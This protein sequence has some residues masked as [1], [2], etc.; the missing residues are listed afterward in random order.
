ML[1]SRFWYVILASL[2]TVGLMA[3]LVAS[4]VVNEQQRSAVENELVR[5]RITLEQALQHEAR[6]RLDALA[7]FAANR[8]VRSALRQASARR[9]GAAVPESVATG[10]A[11][12]IAE[13]NRQ[14][15]ELRGDLVF[16][17]DKEGWIVAALAPGRI[18][19]GA[20]IGE[21]PLVARALEGYMRDDVWVYNDDIYRMAARPV[22]DGGQYVGA[23]I[24]GKR[25]DDELARRLS[26]SRLN[27]ATIGFFLGTEM[28][29]GYMPDEGA[30]PRRDEVGRLLESV[31][32]D[33]ALAEGDRTEPQSLPTGGLAIYSLVQGSAR[34]AGV[35]Y[36]IAR[37]LP[38]LT[39]PWDLLLNTPTEKWAEVA[40]IWWLWA[41]LVGLI[42]FAMLSVWLERDRP[43][44]KMR[45]AA[46]GLTSPEDRLTITDFG[47]QYRTIAQA[48]NDALDRAAEAGGAAGSKRQAAKNLDELLGPADAEPQSS[49]FGFAGQQEASPA[50]IPEPPPAEASPAPAAPPAAPP[51]AKAPPPKPPAPAAAKPTPPIPP[52]PTAAPETSPRAA[53]KPAEAP[54]ANEAPTEAAKP[55]APVP[56]P[57]KVVGRPDAAT[58]KHLK[59]TL[60]G[61]PPPVEDDD[62]DGETMVARVPEEL[63][64]RSASQSLGPDEEDAHF[65]E[66]YEKFVETKKKC[67]EPTAGLTF[68]KFA[69]TLRK[70]R[71][72]IMQR[73][74][75]KKV[76]FTV[77]VKEGKAAL[78][79]TPIRS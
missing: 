57:S 67:G 33:P 66:V 72:Q 69:V 47:G 42:A 43:L 41:V 13:L 51:A 28:K 49:F 77:Y 21:F 24:H 76:R 34:E 35:G 70:N 48:V 65:R 71:D 10:L 9:P 3:A 25:M 45:K 79:A 22:I 61:V 6:T 73:H 5:D 38:T 7:P 40:K 27:G 63:L 26:T 64:A 1:L 2:A 29:A 20:G 31:L 60:L 37:P 53:T 12:K 58:R 11:T 54:A 68:E 44:A 74:G 50:D 78:K 8:D 46:T 14:L 56:G 4:N 36:A 17:V 30:A 19:P 52:P 55:A 62:D 18:P 39:K 59:R 32:E 15:A 16:A 75:A 23:I